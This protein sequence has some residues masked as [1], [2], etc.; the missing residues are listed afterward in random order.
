MTEC[1]VQVS[2]SAWKYIT[3]IP[4]MPLVGSMPTRAHHVVQERL[5]DKAIFHIM[6][7]K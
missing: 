7:A 2:L 6:A 1:N 3:V 4:S 5:P